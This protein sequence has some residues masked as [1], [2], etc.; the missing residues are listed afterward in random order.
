[1]IIFAEHLHKLKKEV[2]LQKFKANNGWL[3]S[4]DFGYQPMVYA[5]LNKMIDSKEIEKVKKGVYRHLSFGHAHEWDELHMYYPQAVLCLFSA[6]QHYELTTAVPYQYHLAFAHKANPTKIDY[7][8]VKFYYWSDNQLLLGITQHENGL[9]I[10]D[11]EKS[12]CDAVKFRNKVGE[13]IMYEVLKNYMNS[14][15]RNIEKLM[16]YAK[17]MR[18]EKIINPMLKPLL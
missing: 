13:E 11:K 8:P 15:D 3:Y 7:P 14:K 12:V 4:K 10:Y 6:W 5:M 18:I 9:R 2:L 16:L 1:M 17:Q